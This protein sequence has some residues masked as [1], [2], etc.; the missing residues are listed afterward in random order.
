MTIVPSD[1]AV[2]SASLQV[3]DAVLLVVI[4]AQVVDQVAQAVLIVDMERLVTREIRAESER[5]YLACPVVVLTRKSVFR[6]NFTL[7]L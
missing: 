7:A 5:T 6:S 4:T 1:S 3:V 2:V